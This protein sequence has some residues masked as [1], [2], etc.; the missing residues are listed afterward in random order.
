MT[1]Q[2]TKT[3]ETHFCIIS[4]THTAELWPPSDTNHA[5]RDPLPS[6]DVLLHA[7]DITYV[8]YIH[9][10]ETMIEM[11]SKADAELKIVIAGN[12]DITLDE[13]YYESTGKRR[14]HRNIGE[15]FSVIKELWTG[16][17]A[18]KAGI[19][20]L[21]EGIR[22][23]TLTNGARF[24]IYTS[25]YQPEFCNWAF[26]YYRNEDRFNPPGGAKN[27]IP[28]WPNIDIMLTHGPPAGVLDETKHGDKVGCW[29][30]QRNNWA[31]NCSKLLTV[32]GSQMLN[33]R[34]AYV[35]LTKD[36]D[37]PLAGFGEETLFVNASIMNVDYKPVNAPNLL[38]AL[39]SF[40]EV[41][42]PGIQTVWSSGKE[43]PE[44]A[45][46]PRASALLELKARLCETSPFFVFLSKELIKVCELARPLIDCIFVVFPSHA[47][48]LDHPVTQTDDHPHGAT[49]PPIWIAPDW[50]DAMRQ[51]WD[52]HGFSPAA[53]DRFMVMLLQSRRK[54]FE[55]QETY[56]QQQRCMTDTKVWHR[57]LQE[58]E[59]KLVESSPEDKD[60]HEVI[61]QRQRKNRDDFV[62][63]ETRMAGTLKETYKCTKQYGL[64]K[65]RA[66][67]I[68]DHHRRGVRIRD[69]GRM[70][71]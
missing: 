43:N 22:T 14:F 31:Q 46:L 25:P 28:D 30:A 27:P 41:L 12:H 11:L 37:E 13:Q 1:P 55:V 53:A 3:V 21:E 61:L 16:E 5:Y 56:A 8:G 60:A 49:I 48:S 39:P 7:G 44:S 20:Y 59:G 50:A 6:A 57:M 34:C 52:F 68:L 29:G 15:D 2:D 35:D 32:H 19:V 70:P 62:E 58:E 42:D 65:A 26:P 33:D 51:A 63:L 45:A 67:D 18:R 9:E 38:V 4:D 69:G 66:V 54:V 47:P 17:K 40:T 64:L 71:N 10:Y 36:G 24:T 23:F